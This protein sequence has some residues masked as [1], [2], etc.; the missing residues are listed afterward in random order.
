MEHDAGPAGAPGAGALERLERAVMQPLTEH[1]RGFLALAAGL[2]FVTGWG[3][4]AWSVQLRR[5]LAVT[6]LN[7]LVP[8]GFYITNFVM[9][10]GI[11]HAGTFISAILRLTAVAWRK[12]VV[13]MAEFMTIAS[14]VVGGMMP[15]VD[16]GRPER[17]LNLL[18]FGRLESP[19]LW[20]LISVT[21]YLVG[22]LIYLYIPL[23]P[24]IARCRDRLAGKVPAWRHRLY[25]ALAAGWRDTPTQ[26]RALERG[27]RIMCLVI[28]PV[29]ISVHTVVSWIFAMT[30]RT[31]WHSTIFGP[32][33][34]VG[35]IYSG[36]A[37][38]ITGMAVF[39]RAYRLQ[40][41]FTDKHFVYLGNLLLATGLF[42]F[43]FT[44]AEYLTIGYKLEPADRALLTELTLG[45]FAPMFWFWWIA[46]WL[47]PVLLLAL[48]RTR[49]A[50]GVVTASVLINI[51]MWIKRYFIIIP[52]LSL[53]LLP[54]EWAVYRPTWVEFSII[55]AAFTGFALLVAGLAK[56]FPLI[57][58][59]ELE[60]DL[61]AEGAATAEGRRA[62]HRPPAPVPRPAVA[63]G[64]EAGSAGEG[65]GGKG[66]GGHA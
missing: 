40:E 11:S 64:G 10:I 27:I 46:G 38:V 1:T 49:N 53:P 37:A 45:R 12:P 35:A 66:G 58:V 65:A 15:L 60:E 14:L 4:Y 25:T 13:R 6:G 20:D 28:I 8:W 50:V 55:F 62:D 57:S 5:G 32:Y 16:L 51:G 44:F 56:L 48:P 26:R 3:A 41:W 36:I 33:F 63:W 52:T 34:V 7:D 18:R 42:Y 29:M 22:S 2:F 43:Y 54:Y 39:R 24:D 19:I 61:A 21:S 30:L 47:V 23:I 17:V 59:W 31:G 9:F